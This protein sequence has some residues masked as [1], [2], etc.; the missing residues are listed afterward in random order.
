MNLEV[1]LSAVVQGVPLLFVV[2]VI[3]QF[4]KSLKGKDGE[5]LLKHN[6]ILVS[7]L[8]VGVALGVGYMVF[9]TP[10]PL[11]PEGDWYALYGYVFGAIIYGL[12]LGGA[13]SVFWDAL[14]TIAE[15]MIKR[16]LE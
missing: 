12:G 7:S 10:P 5:Q 9:T 4:L 14:K 11:P 13:A 16:L 6:A 1:Y 15:T 2:F 3:V 8:L